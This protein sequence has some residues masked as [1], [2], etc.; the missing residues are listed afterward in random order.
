MHDFLVTEKKSA[1]YCCRM[2]DFSAVQR[3]W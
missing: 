1:G 2:A 3:L